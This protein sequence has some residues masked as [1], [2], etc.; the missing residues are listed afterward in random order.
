MT[1][2]EAIEN[3]LECCDEYEEIISQLQEENSFLTETIEKNNLD[4]IVSER[5]SLLDD[6]KQQELTSELKTK[7]AEAIKME[8]SN[9]LNELNERLSDVKAKQDN[10]DSYIDASAEAKVT[11]ERRE[12]QKYKSA[13]DQA[14]K[15]HMAEC[16]KRLKEEIVLYKEKRKKWLIT[17]ICGILFGII[18]IVI[19]FV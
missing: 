11:D 1:H 15:K 6:I 17:A 13:N 14:L 3:L 18:G 8:Y 9:K 2:D 12:Y 4:K 7:N 16:D 19:N 5:R 10:I